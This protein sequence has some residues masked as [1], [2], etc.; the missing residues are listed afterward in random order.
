MPLH[1]DLREFIELLNSHRVEYLIVGGY[2]PAF[3]G[4]PRYT[5]DIDILIR[6]SFENAGRLEQVISAF[7]FADTGLGA[8]GFLT[9]DQIV[10][11]GQRQTALTC[12]LRSLR[13]DST[14]RGLTRISHQLTVGARDRPATTSLR[15]PAVLNVLARLDAERKS[16]LVSVAPS[17]ARASARPESSLPD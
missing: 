8:K 1:S 7:G 11:L 5:G 14:R 9:L 13:L 2:A 16:L 10:Q 6:A 15:L 12:T 17:C 4:H 3:H